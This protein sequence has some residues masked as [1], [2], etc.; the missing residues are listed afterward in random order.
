MAGTDSGDGGRGIRCLAAV[1][2]IVVGAGLIAWVVVARA[3]PA[4]S[5]PL[6]LQAVGDQTTIHG[7]AR[8]HLEDGT[9]WEYSL[10]S[11]VEGP[12]R[13]ET[14]GLAKR[15][16]PAPGE[17]PLPER[18]SAELT[19]LCQ[20]MDCCGEDGVVTRLASQA[21]KPMPGRWGELGGQRVWEFR[22]ETADA[23]AAGQGEGHPEAWVI[24]VDPKTKLVRA[25]EVSAAGSGALGLRARCE[26]EYGKPLPA[27]FGDAPG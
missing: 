12:G 19:E 14:K 1:F 20:A 6:V 5:W 7:S 26:Y 3:R 17:S 9:M 2:A 10:W 4:V 21:D 16:R 23:T 8:I 24:A 27:G 15:A 22:L 25:L 13:C 18:P 11:R